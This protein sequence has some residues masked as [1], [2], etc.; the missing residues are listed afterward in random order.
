MKFQVK[1]PI[2][3][4]DSETCV[5]YQLVQIFDCNG[6]YLAPGSEDYPKVSGSKFVGDGRPFVA[7]YFL[8]EQGNPVEA[9]DVPPVIQFEPC[10]EL[11]F[12]CADTETDPC[13][14]NGQSPQGR[15]KYDVNP[16]SL[17]QDTLNGSEITVKLP[18]GGACAASIEGTYP[19]T[20]TLTIV[21]ASNG[22]PSVQNFV[23]A[24]NAIGPNFTAEAI[25]MDDAGTNSIM[26]VTV[27]TGL[28]NIL[29]QISTPGGSAWT[30]TWD[31]TAGVWSVEDDNGNNFVGGS[32]AEC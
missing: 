32:E 4:W 22:D 20:G 23:D 17:S 5:R 31:D 14:G 1:D 2:F 12:T 10:V 16:S 30:Q 28:G 26:C 9:A 19:I 29:I 3:V 6:N 13:D 11:C 15:V 27:P 7:S 21:P 18:D 25:G 24:F 8:T